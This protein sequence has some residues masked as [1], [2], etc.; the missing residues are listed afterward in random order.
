[1]KV[2]EFDY[3]LDPS[4]I[5]QA[6]LERRDASRLM[7]LD[8]ET[9]RVEHR[10]FTDL[11]GLLAPRDLLVLNDTRVICARL[12]GRKATGGRAELLLVERAE[13]DGPHGWHCLG[14]ARRPPAT[15]SILEFAEGLRGRVLGCEGGG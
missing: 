5:A 7:L 11:V 1:M 10:R 8:R 9:G 12:I 13:E 4:R 6:P 15:G 2:D 3:E 14:Q